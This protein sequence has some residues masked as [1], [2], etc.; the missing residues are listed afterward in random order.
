[1]N[2]LVLSQIGLHLEHSKAIV[3]LIGVFPGMNEKVFSQPGAAAEQL[4]TILTSIGH[5]YYGCVGASIDHTCA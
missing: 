3:T 4:H 1:M 5:F 2:Q